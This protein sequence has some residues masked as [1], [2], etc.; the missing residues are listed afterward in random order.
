MVGLG[1]ACVYSLILDVF[2]L[3]SRTQQLFV[4]TQS[5]LLTLMSLIS[6]HACTIIFSLFSSLL[7]LLRSCS[8]INF[9]SLVLPAC[10]LHPARAQMPQCYIIKTLFFC[11]LLFCR[12]DE[13]LKLTLGIYSC[14]NWWWQ[15]RFSCKY[16]LYFQCLPV[17]K[18]RPILHRCLS[19]HPSW[20]VNRQ[21]SG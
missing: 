20:N 8:L 9:T 6:E 16:L 18:Q 15:C 19:R 4:T 13:S 17:S 2:I 7:A 3:C 10:L 12:V 1:N 5:Y 11:F 14:S 21:K